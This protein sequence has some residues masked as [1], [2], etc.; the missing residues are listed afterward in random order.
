[1][2]SKALIWICATVGS[3]IGGFIPS[4]WG[5][6]M[7]SLSPLIFGS[8]GAVIGIYLGFKINN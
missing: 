1:M 7:F 6:D 8:I 2:N 4:L 3:I 5:A